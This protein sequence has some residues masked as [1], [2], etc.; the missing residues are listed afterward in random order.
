[1]TRAHPKGPPTPTDPPAAPKPQPAP[2]PD[3]HV[4][5]DEDIRLFHEGTHLRLYDKLGAHAITVAGVS[6]MQFAMWAPNAAQVSVIGDFNQWNRG[7]HPLHLHGDSG[8]WEGFIP[9]ATPGCRYK[10]HILSRHRGHRADKA[11]PFAF[12]S[13]TPPKNASVIWEL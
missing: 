5:T 13:E 10:Y 11:D 6:G 3:P 4:L 9:D 7:R 12:Y 1:S 2:P 8:I